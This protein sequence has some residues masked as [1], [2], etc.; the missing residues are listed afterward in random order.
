MTSGRLKTREEKI[1]DQYAKFSDPR[2]FTTHNTLTEI[3][4]RQIPQEVSEYQY[5]LRSDELKK[6]IKQFKKK[7]PNFPCG[8]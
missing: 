5:G 7:H 8:I 2:W 1:V 4:N 6:G 3:L